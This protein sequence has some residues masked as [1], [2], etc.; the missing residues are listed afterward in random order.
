M[1]GDVCAPHH[2]LRSTAVPHKKLWRLMDAMGAEVVCDLD[3][4]TS[5][6]FLLTVTRDGEAIV[7]ETFADKRDALARSVGLFKDLKKTVKT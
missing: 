2:V 6:R 5:H 1:A 7:K 4:L 3:T